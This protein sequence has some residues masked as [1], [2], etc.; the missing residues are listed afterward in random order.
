MNYRYKLNSVRAWFFFLHKR[1]R[2]AEVD[3]TV[4]WLFYWE[5]NKQTNKRHTWL[6]FFLPTVAAAKSSR[7]FYRQLQSVYINK[8]I[9]WQYLAHVVSI[10]SS[11]ASLVLS[12]GTFFKSKLNHGKEKLKFLLRFVPNYSLGKLTSNA[13]SKTKMGCKEAEDI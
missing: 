10:D 9:C 6:K 8:P 13:F 12:G 1:K 2:E 3:K 7:Y 11:C 5:K 4:V